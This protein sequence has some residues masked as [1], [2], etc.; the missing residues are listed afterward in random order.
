MEPC[1]FSNEKACPWQDGLS[2]VNAGQTPGQGGR[3]DM[4]RVLLLAIFCFIALGGCSQDPGTEPEKGV[5]PRAAPAM[6]D[7]N[8]A[9][10]LA[11]AYVLNNPGFVEE[12]LAFVS[13]NR[14]FFVANGSAIRGMRSLGVKLTQA[15]LNAY[16]P[17]ALERAYRTGGPPELAEG[18]AR[19][20]NSWST[21]IVCMGQELA[22]L[23]E[24][25]PAAAEGDWNPYLT[26]RTLCRNLTHQDAI[27]RL[28]QLDQLAKISGNSELIP[29]FLSL[30]KQYMPLKEDEVF[31]M[32]VMY[33]EY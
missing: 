19:K 18:V 3:T 15:A 24:V 7:E 28:K 11:R 4:F 31:V 2:V 16:D 20:I 22:W 17:Q 9:R 21:E 27:I 6:C 12:M 25:L 26:T 14:S 5:P 30:L 29:Q 8:T 23:A 1:A 33:G 13:Q 32:A 10:V